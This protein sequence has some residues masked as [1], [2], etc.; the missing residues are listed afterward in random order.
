MIWM[1]WRQ[2]RTQ[3]VIGAAA[4]AV[5]AIYLVILGFQIRHT[6]HA[7]GP[8]GLTDRYQVRIYLLDG[9]L[10]LV[11]VLVGAFWGAPLVARELEAGTHRLAW[12][13]S[14]TRT[15][16]LAVKLLVVG[17]AAMAV[18]GLASLLLTW[19]ASPYDRVAGERFTALTFAA[20]N[21][22]PVGYAAFAFLLGTV[23]GLALRRTVA[24]MA[25][26]IAVLAV[27]QVFMPT[28]VRPH[29]STPVTA[30]VPV[31]VRMV[32]NLTFLGVHGNVGGVSVPDAWVVSTSD[33]LAADGQRVDMVDYNRCMS[34]SMDRIGQCL[35]A[36]HLHVRVAYQPADRYWSFQWRESAI[37]A[38]LAAAL[39]GLGLWRIRRR[40]A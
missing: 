28:M 38:A 30:D 25:L 32:R 3:A 11:P 31:T 33:L 21:V 29:L 10:I 16:W 8:A 14:I 15:R 20:R 23:L 12:N 17:L 34:G 40:L 22:T 19:A 9:L 39:A 6:Y 35:A 18:T 26:T 24:A 37:Y 2:F 27:V 13:Q 7:D 1:S 5:L 36:L 4:L